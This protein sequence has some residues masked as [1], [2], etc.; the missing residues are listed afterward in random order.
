MPAAGVNEANPVDDPTNVLEPVR[1]YGNS[2]VSQLT[3]ANAA[4][5]RPVLSKAAS[6]YAR[7]VLGNNVEHAPGHPTAIDSGPF[8]DDVL[9]AP[10]FVSHQWEDAPTPNAS[11]A[12][13]LDAVRLPIPLTGNPA[14]GAADAHIPVPVDDFF[15]A[16]RPLEGA[17]KGAIE[18]A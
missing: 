13:P 10:R 5:A 14:I 4:S 15:G 6:D 1:I 12:T 8:A 7:R 9:F 17:S 16:I 18:P 3:G 11:F 2:F